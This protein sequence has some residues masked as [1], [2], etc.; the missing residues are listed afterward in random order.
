M[1]K[2]SMNSTFKLNTG[3]LIP[4]IGLGTYKIRGAEVFPAIDFALEIGYRHIGSV[5]IAL[6]VVPLFMLL[7]LLL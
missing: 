1:K 7:F 3:Y 6:Y 4:L 2:N 5:N